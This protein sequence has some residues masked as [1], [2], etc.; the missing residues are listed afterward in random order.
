MAHDNSLTESGEE[1]SIAFQDIVESS[2]VI[3][4][5]ASDA[6]I[7]INEDSRILF[8]NRAAVNI[9]GHSI[10]EMLGSKL[11]MLMPEYLRHLHRDGLKHY[12]ETG[13]KHISWNAVELPGL[14][15][16]GKEISLELSFGEFSKYGKRF[17]TGIARDI[18]K[19]KQDE[20]RLA[21][22]HSVAEILAAA[23]SL[24]EAT[25]RLLKA[26]CEN[27]GWQFGALWAVATEL[28][29]LQLVSYWRDESLDTG[30]EFEATSR[31]SRFTRG[32]GFP[33]TVWAGKKP[34][35]IADFAS[36]SFHRSSVAARGNLHSAFGFPVVL[37]HEVLAVIELF[38][39][40]IKE[41]DPLVLGTLLVI[42]SQ[43]GQFIERKNGEQELVNALKCAHEARVEA[44][45]LTKQ[46]GALQRM[47]DAALAHLSVDEVLEESLNRIREVLKVDTVAILLLETEGD[48]LVA[49]AAQGLEEEVEQGLRIPVGK[50]FAGRVVAEGKPIIIDDVSSADVF[51]PLL[52]ERGIKSLLGVPLLVEGRPTGVVHVGKL[53]F[54]HFTNEDVQ[55]LQLAAD[56]IA[57]AIESARL[58]EVERD[59]RAAAEA[60]NSAKDEFLTILSHE[61][62]TPLTPII[63][64]VHMMQNGILPDADFSRVLSVINRNAY[65]LKRLINDLLDM[66]AILSGKMRIE[67]APVPVAGVLGESV[68]TMRAY[69]LDSKVKLQLKIAD[70]AAGVIIKGDRS[71]LNQTF[72]NILHNAIKFSP[73]GACVQASLEAT[74]SEAIV[75]IKDEGEGIPAGFLP[76]VFERF[77]QADGSRTR[78]FGGLGL[79]LALVKSFVEAH[80][81][82]VEAASEGE[83]KGSMFIVRLPREVEQPDGAKETE[84][85]RDSEGSKRRT[86][87]LIVEDQPDTLEMLA[88]NFETRGYEI[89]ACNSAVEALKVAGREHF[90]VLVSDIAMPTMDGLQLIKNLRQHKGLERVPAIALTGYASQRDVDAATAAGFDIHLPKPIDPA[91]LAAAVERLLSSKSE[92]FSG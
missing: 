45:A 85:K 66:S 10:E 12:V 7:T 11:T 25:P 16:N 42:G 90:D 8:V 34:I 31:E 41:A 79:G 40:E 92:N 23:P 33:G 65:S 22:Q 6:I 63:G 55:L 24:A 49:W 46:L 91:D 57:L 20:R 74:G 73:A 9:F 18:T 67:E 29:E 56:R 54:C 4:D 13:Q 39:K 19:R 50:G 59:A 15:K 21:L 1:S 82:I 77:R 72:C 52:R 62:R 87:V 76:H 61:L 32:V 60:A 47:T 14:H 81:G 36:D 78:A 83:G 35:W 89:I 3:A 75:N 51:N 37:G 27:V 53:E 86:R 38:S 64:W 70:D 80:G 28:D 68:E 58:Y 44:E 88:A 84:Y 5:T 30:A 2:R 43:I 26:I 17:F 71:R 48:E 69:A